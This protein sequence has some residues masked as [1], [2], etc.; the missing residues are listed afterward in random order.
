MKK[1]IQIWLLCLISTVACSQTNNTKKYA[2]SLKMLV[3]QTTNDTLKM[4]ALSNK[5]N[6]KNE[7]L[8]IHQSF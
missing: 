1:I 3:M 5:L 8:N 7:I 4:T 2:D 6:Y